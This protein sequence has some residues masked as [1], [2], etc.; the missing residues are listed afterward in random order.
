MKK[1]LA[2]LLLF[3]CL[4]A[5]QN[6]ATK[7]PAVKKKVEAAASEDRSHETILFRNDFTTDDRGVTTTRP[8]ILLNNGAKRP[9]ETAFLFL[10]PPDKFKALGLE[11]LNLILVLSNHRALMEVNNRTSYRPKKVSLIYSDEDQEWTCAVR[12]TAKNDEG[13]AN[14]F[15]AFYTY[16]DSGKFKEA[17]SEYRP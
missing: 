10:A 2:L 5:A 9:V 8:Y 6:K 7:K 11:Q 16:D 1:L 4:L 14:E 3:P 15:S 17:L 13:V 12:F